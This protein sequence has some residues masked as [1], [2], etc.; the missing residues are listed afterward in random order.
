[1]VRRW[2][3]AVDAVL[4]DGEDAGGPVLNQS[5][6][7][8]KRKKPISSDFLV[9]DRDGAPNGTRVG[10]LPNRAGDS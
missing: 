2:G 9:Y 1:M 10:A 6:C 4:V 5:R 3:E 7:P 8:A